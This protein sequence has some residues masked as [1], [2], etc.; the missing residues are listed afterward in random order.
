M[1]RVLYKP[2]PKSLETHENAHAVLVWSSYKGERIV[3]QGIHTHQE[4]ILKQTKDF[5]T[6]VSLLN[7]SPSLSQTKIWLRSIRYMIEVSDRARRTPQQREPFF[8][9]DFGRMDFSEPGRGG[10]GIDAWD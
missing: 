6:A 2:F 7:S 9:A 10:H 3:V 5:E 4:R 8:R 1:F